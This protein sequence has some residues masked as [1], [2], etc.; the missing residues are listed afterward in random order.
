MILI[1]AY[2]NSLRRDDGAGFVLADV[3]EDLLSGTGA[4]ARRIDSHQLVPELAL[5]IAAEDVSAVVFADA[6]AVLSASDG[7]EV[8]VS[9]V[10]PAEAASPS[11]GHNLDASVL[12]AYAKHLFNRE[13]RAWLIT[14]PGVDFDHGEGLSKTTRKSLARAPE[15]LRELVELLAR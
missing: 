1:L 14:V 7:L 12:M 10:L 5:D 9:E 6:R 11:A 13:V 3:L 15:R 4:E 2:G 8:G